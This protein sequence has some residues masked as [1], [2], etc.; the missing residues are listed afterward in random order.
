MYPS[1][2]YSLTRIVG[3]PLYYHYQGLCENFECLKLGNIFIINVIY[4][5]FFHL[6]FINCRFRILFNFQNTNFKLILNDLFFPNTICLK[7]FTFSGRYISGFDSIF[8]I[9]QFGTLIGKV[10]VVDFKVVFHFLL[11]VIL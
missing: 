1:N 8:T 6:I 4:T 2:Q 10:F 9:S 5:N 11:V 3:P 7:V